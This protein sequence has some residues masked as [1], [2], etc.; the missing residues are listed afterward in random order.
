VVEG[1]CAK[2]VGAWDQQAR[3]TWTWRTDRRGARGGRGEGELGSTELEKK[4]R[5]ETWNAA[6]SLPRNVSSCSITT[7]PMQTSVPADGPSERRI[8]KDPIGRLRC[9]RKLRNAHGREAV[10]PRPPRR[11]STCAVSVLHGSILDGY[12]YSHVPVRGQ[13]RACHPGVPVPAPNMRE[14]RGSIPRDSTSRGK[15]TTDSGS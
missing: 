10:A 6:R 9:P 12:Q 1:R 4:R 14:V 13:A 2:H 15:V 7:R 3:W 8:G 11:R 5:N